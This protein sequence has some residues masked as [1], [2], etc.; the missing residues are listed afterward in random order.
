[1][2]KVNTQGLLSLLETPTTRIRCFDMGRRVTELTRA[3][4]TAFEQTTLAYPLPL[5]NQAWFALCRISNNQQTEPMVWFLRLPLDEQ[6]KL[7]LATRDYFVHRLLDAIATS[8]PDNPDK[9]AAA[10]E[11]NPH[12]FKPREDRMAVFHAQL[13]YSLG[14]PPSSFFDHA[15]E[16]FSGN[17]GWDQWQFVGYQGIADVAARSENIDQAMTIGRAIPHLPAEPLTALCHCLENQPISKPVSQALLARLQT[18]LSSQTVDTALISALIRGLS[19]ATD[20]EHRQQ[21]FQQVFASPCR[22]DIEILVSISGRAWEVLTSPGNGLIFMEALAST[23]GGQQVFEDCIRDL[24]G[25]PGLRLI[26]L[27]A[28]KKSDC[29]TL[30]SSRMDALKTNHGE[31]SAPT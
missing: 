25:L 23:A 15:M 18:L 21:K 8:D 27:D 14:L 3:Q 19:Q 16:Y 30:L 5:K 13:G 17:T 31:G 4:F 7:V 11:D 1:M 10:F 12:T 29:S 26:L 9:L 22:T 2:G 20:S 28:M 6:N 24:F